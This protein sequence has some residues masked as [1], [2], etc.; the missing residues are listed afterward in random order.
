MKRTLPTLL[1]LTGALPFLSATLS[2]IAGGPFHPTISIVILVTYAAVILSFLGGIQWGIAISVEA[3]APK[4]AQ[5]LFI[6]SVVTALLAWGVLWLN[7]P[8]QQIGASLVILLAV[9]GLDGLLRVQNL[10][11]AWFFRLRSIA[12]AIVGTSLVAALIKL[13]MSA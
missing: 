6:L 10:I 13:S 7:N 3:T 4:S 2:L 11:P 8:V 1:V 9:W 5:R 12:T